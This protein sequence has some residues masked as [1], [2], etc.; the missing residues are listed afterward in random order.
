MEIKGECFFCENEI[1]GKSCYGGTSFEGPL[2]SIGCCLDCA[3]QLGRLLAGAAAELPSGASR[4]EW[5]TRALE[6]LTAEAWEALALQL[7]GGREAEKLLAA[8]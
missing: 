6:R 8:V 5:L 3:P 2:V 7:D 1:G 4:A